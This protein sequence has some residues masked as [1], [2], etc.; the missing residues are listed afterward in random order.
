M[1]PKIIHHVWVGPNPLPEEERRYIESWKARHKDYEFFFWTDENIGELYFSDNCKVAMRESGDKYALKADIV[2][3]VA[4]NKF[5]GFY[6][7]ADMRCRRKISK[8]IEGWEDFIGLTSLFG[9]WI[10]N[11]FFASV[12][13]GSI[14]T[15]L[16]SN[17]NILKSNNTNPYGPSFLD[18]H[19][20]ELYNDKVKILGTDFWDGGV[21]AYVHHDFKH[22]WK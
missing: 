20:R 16:I 14:L 11:G 22:S 13:N 15:S 9:N 12:P 17:I 8:I 21:N 7:D 6:I 5:G 3:Y 2:R 19:M 10:C 1:I 18:Y 4:V